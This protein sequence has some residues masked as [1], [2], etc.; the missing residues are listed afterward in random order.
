MYQVLLRLIDF[1]FLL[2]FCFFSP[3]LLF[4]NVFVS[5]FKN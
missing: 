1:S 5:D 2:S 3:I 4:F